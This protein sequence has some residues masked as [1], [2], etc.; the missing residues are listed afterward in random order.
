MGNLFYLHQMLRRHIY[1]SEELHKGAC[2]T[3]HCCSV[4][5]CVPASFSKA[6]LIVLGRLLAGICLRRLLRG[7][8]RGGSC[9]VA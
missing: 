7:K 5:H 9:L 3:R 4:L 1:M 6:Q 8:F 2:S